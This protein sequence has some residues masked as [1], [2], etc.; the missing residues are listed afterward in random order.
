[1]ATENVNT[2]PMNPV[3]DGLDWNDHLQQARGII[4]VC[5]VAMAVG[6]AATSAEG[7]SD[8]AISQ[9]LWRAEISIETAM[10]Q[11]RPHDQG[12]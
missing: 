6:V 5:R 11:L 4:D 3:N 2:R 12:L 8:N 7:L 10:G 1:M 9:A